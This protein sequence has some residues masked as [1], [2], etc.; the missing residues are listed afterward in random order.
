[1]IEFEKSSCMR[2]P[3]C[4]FAPLFL[5][6]AV[7]TATVGGAQDSVHF[8]VTADVRIEHARYDEVLAA[9]NALVGGQGDFQVSTGDMDGWIW[10]NR[11]L[12]DSRMGSS[13]IWIP[14]IGNHE[15]EDPVEMDWVR[16]E[17]MTGNGERTALKDLMVRDGPAGSWETTY[18]WDVGNAHFVY[19]NEYWNGSTEPGSD[20][21]TDGDVVPDLLAWLTADLQAN[22]QPAIFVFGHEPA[23]PFHRHLY[24]S[25]NKYEANRDAFWE[26]L[27]REAVIA[28][29]CGHTHVFSTYQPPGSTVW[30]ID[31]G[32]AGN[33]SS[34][35]DGQSFRSVTVSRAEVQ[36]EVCRNRDGPFSCAPGWSQPLP[37]VFMDGFESGNLDR[38]LFGTAPN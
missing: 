3:M 38:W 33:D 10:E 20:V 11:A 25:L 6:C 2:K 37:I 28:Y 27:E 24:D 30:Q 21:A 9:M 22:S 34:F 13:A 14:G 15:A 5:L 4:L 17:F 8:T 36:F 1:M 31:V 12:V 7:S 23:F 16:S 26:L 19:L 29:V 35:L 32:N 18:S